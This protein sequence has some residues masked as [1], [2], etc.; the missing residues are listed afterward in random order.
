MKSK[1]DTSNAALLPRIE[2]RIQTIR[3]LRVM[4]DADLAALYGVPTRALNQAVKRN[5]A[6]FPSDFMFRL[7]ASE[8]AEVITNCDHL[9]NLKFSKALP[10]AFTEHGAIQAANVL[11]SEQAVEMGVY[12]VRAFVQLR[13][14]L[15]AHADVAKR[16]AALEMKTEHLELSH[17]N[18][19]HNT[20][21][22]L[23]ELLE[24][25]K[26]L[27]TPPNPPKHAIGFVTQNEKKAAPGKPVAMKKRPAGKQ[28]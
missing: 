6:R 23:R 10:H 20:R 18:F 25:V 13:E 22:Q 11:A 2:N 26:E 1:T 7:D 15:F 28:S 21:R 16:L 17:D 24:A 14:A 19:S 3:G 9:Q 8:K 5:A 12:V 27:T 4:I